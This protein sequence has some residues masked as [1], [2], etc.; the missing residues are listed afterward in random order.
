LQYVVDPYD[1]FDLPTVEGFNKF[2]PFV[3]DHARMSKT[4][5]IVRQRPT[6]LILGGSSMEGGLDP[7][8]PALAAWPAAYN[9][10]LPSGR[11]Y[12]SYRLL[13]HA[14]AQGRVELAIVSL[15][16]IN[17]AGIPTINAPGFSETALSMSLHGQ[18]NADVLSPPLKQ[19]FR[20]KF[21]GNGLVTLSY[22]DPRVLVKGTTHDRFPTHWYLKNGQR[23]HDSSQR[24]GIVYRGFDAPF[25]LYMQQQQARLVSISADDFFPARVEGEDYF[26]LIRR[27]VELSAEKN[28]R[29][30]FMMPP[31]HVSMLETQIASGVWEQ[32]GIFKERVVATLDAAE[33][34]MGHHIPVY[35]FCVYAQPNAEPIFSRP[36]QMVPPLTYWDPIHLN[37]RTGDL[38]LSIMFGQVA[39]IEGF[40]VDLRGVGS[41]RH[42]MTQELSR[43]EELRRKMRDEFSSYASILR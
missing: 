36:D 10:A 12:E 24:Y 4:Q 34:G 2:K 20:P 14:I 33:R 1:Y 15:D 32:F 41:I 17:W 31:C 13:Q 30:I 23:A 37:S 28:I 38:A 8:H 43:R 40:G 9:A 6:A 3:Y 39:P 22:Q 7:A 27:F 16:F 21:I 26:A 5:A 19:I 42:Y 35:D 11:F 25:R 18:P 29:L